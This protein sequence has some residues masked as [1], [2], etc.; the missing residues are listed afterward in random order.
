MQTEEY[1]K[2]RSQEDTYWW[3]VSRRRLARALIAKY[4]ADAEAVLDLGCGTGAFLSELR[5]GS[6]RIGL[7]FSEHAVKFCAE[8]G[9][10]GVVQG[11]AQ[12]LPFSSNHF[13]L[14]VSL[15]TLE[16]V[17]EDK[18]ALNELFRVL[19]PGAI[20]VINVPAYGWLWGP[21]DVALMHRRRYTVGSLRKV[22][23]D[24]GFR[25]KKCSYSVFFMFPIVV[26][27]RLADKFRR[28][29]ATVHLPKTPKHLNQ[30]LVT[31]QDLEC[32]LLLNTFLPWGSSVIVVA[33]KADRS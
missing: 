24:T 22:L 19:K 12:S 27:I 7:D 13:D 6:Q 31:L 28:G 3:F 25:V 18:L 8:R 29:P 2:M 17:P 10:T 11:D 14:C 16:H 9:I 4:S 23:E 20:V 32:W 26:L 5:T 21:H 33:Q 15:D 1:D 30:F